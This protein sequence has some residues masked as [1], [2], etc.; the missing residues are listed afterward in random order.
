[1]SISP[2]RDRAAGQPSSAGR[3]RGAVVGLVTNNKDPENRARIKVKFPWLNDDIESHW[4]PVMQFYAGKGRGGFI[5]PEVGD[6]VLLMFEDGDPD[7]PY[8]V[9]SLWNGKDTPP[10]GGNTDGSNNIKQFKSRSG[11]RLIFDDTEGAE[12]ITLVNNNDKLKIEIDVAAD[13]ITFLATSG[14]IFFK[15]P[16]GP[17][18]LQ[19]KEMKVTASNSSTVKVGDTHG[20]SSKNRTETVG[21][22]DSATAKQSITIATKTLSATFGSGSVEA[23]TSSMS[24]QGASMQTMGTVEIEGAV[25]HRKTGPETLTAGILEIHGKQDVEFQLSGAATI[26]A[27]MMTMDSGAD[28]F[29]ESAAVLT[30]MGGM[31][32]YNG[33]AGLQ[34][35][36]SLVTLC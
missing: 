4:A 15:A 36:A 20:E 14:D 27:G 5:L 11:H 25:V 13:S 29:I 24:V 2:L 21:S 18:S 32:N 10:G 35:A 16:Q 12:K 34:V 6:E 26:T 22:S 23:K 19:C 28:A 33:G 30:V 9:G 8:V 7:L 31:V 17:I 1:M 3:I